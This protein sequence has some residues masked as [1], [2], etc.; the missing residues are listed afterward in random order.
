VANADLYCRELAEDDDGAYWR[1]WF[2]AKP[3]IG[4]EYIVV[5][6]QWSYP[7]DG[8]GPIRVRR[9]FATRTIIAGHAAV[10]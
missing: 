10:P 3:L 8:T 4:D 2:C 7:E 6:D 1:E 9:I 5:R